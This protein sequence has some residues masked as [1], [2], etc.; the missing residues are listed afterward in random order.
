MKESS[1]GPALASAALAGRFSADISCRMS[2]QG[3]MKVC[4]LIFIKGLGG[5]EF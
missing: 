4:E 3:K 1:A 2:K 5:V